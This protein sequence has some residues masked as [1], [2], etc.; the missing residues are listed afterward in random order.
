M[1]SGGKMGCP[2]CGFEFNRSEGVGFFFP[3]DYKESVEKAK[4]GK[5]GKEIK[6][7]FKEHADGAINASYVTLCC[8]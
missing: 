6:Q 7:F 1:G 2:Q 5:L 8:D 3:Q 4:S